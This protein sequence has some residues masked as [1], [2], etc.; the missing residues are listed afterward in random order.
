MIRGLLGGVGRVTVRGGMLVGFW[1]IYFYNVWTAGKN[2]DR[3]SPEGRRG[4]RG[5]CTDISQGA[6]L[7]VLA[8]R[9][10]RLIR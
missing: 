10:Q 3:R 8:Y 1:W 7:P 2:V 5:G 4:R 9:M 6:V